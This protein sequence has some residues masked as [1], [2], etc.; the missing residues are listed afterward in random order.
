MHCVFTARAEQDLEAIAAYIA[1]DNPVRAL[2]FV[3][4]IRE[5]CEKIVQIPQGYQFAP[6]YGKEVRKVP[7]GDYLILYAV[8]DESVIILHIPHGARN[9]PDSLLR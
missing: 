6:E 2:S 3:Q 8:Q 7:F 4:E 1:C 9:L 5:R